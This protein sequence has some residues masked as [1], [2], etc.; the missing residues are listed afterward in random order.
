VSIRA[1]LVALVVGCAVVLAPHP[2]AGQVEA[3][4]VLRG[5]VR[6][7]DA[8]PDVLP[9]GL[10]DTPVILHR[11]GPDTAGEIDSARIAPDGSFSFLLPYVPDPGSRGREIF[12]ASLEHEGILYF[13]R[14]ITTAVQLDSLYVI[15]AYDTVTVPTGGATLPVSVR[16]LVLEPATAPEGAP[17]DQ[18]GG[19]RV[20]DLVQVENPGDRTLTAADSGAVWSYP[21]PEEAE[22]VQIGG[23]DVG[24]DATQIEE[25]RVVVYAPL[26]PGQRQLIV[27]YALE[28][29][30]LTVPLP[31]STGSVELLVREPAPSLRVEGLDPD[32][33]VQMETGSTYRRYVGTN[34]QEASV[35]IVED[36]GAEEGGWSPRWLAVLL[37]LLLAGVGL[38]AVLKHPPS[39]RVPPAGRPDPAPSRSALLLEIARIDESLES[40]H[41][42]DAEELELR[43]RRTALLERLGA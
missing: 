14:A 27:R 5:V 9:G 43:Q 25:G 33:P 3:E 18:G 2:V 38:W 7:G 16:Y 40:G 11:V 31:G 8:E 37:G 21:L 36:E 4:P 30:E 32:R 29:P 1:P 15:Q 17:L 42:E 41:L 6:V 23:G 10:A 26:P 39:T 35:R 34:L 28:S 22:R 24:P 19:W 20:T 12:F 13:G